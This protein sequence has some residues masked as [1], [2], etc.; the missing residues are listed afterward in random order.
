M[1]GGGWLGSSSRGADVVG[2]AD[3]DAVEGVNSTLHLVDRLALV[4]F[5][6]YLATIRPGTF[7]PR[8]LGK[9]AEDGV[10]AG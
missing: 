10:V 5:E 3:N 7:H 6:S 2:R 4:G 1:G 9:E 8:V